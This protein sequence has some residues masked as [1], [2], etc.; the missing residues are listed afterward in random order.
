[1][2]DQAALTLGGSMRDEI[3]LDFKDAIAPLRGLQPTPANKEKALLLLGFWADALA[4][5]EGLTIKEAR[6]ILKAATM[7]VK[8]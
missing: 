4:M 2:E 1:M 3:I 7:E 5:T 8:P 6:E